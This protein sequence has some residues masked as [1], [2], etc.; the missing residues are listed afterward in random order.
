MIST[1]SNGFV[2]IAE[3]FSSGL[4]EVSISNSFDKYSALRRSP[5]KKMI[6][7]KK[8]TKDIDLVNLLQK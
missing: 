6:E 2:G 7:I 4:V 8:I 5:F 3:P 1:I